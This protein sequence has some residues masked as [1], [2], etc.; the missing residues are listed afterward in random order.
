VALAEKG[1]AFDLEL[2]K[3]WERRTEFLE[4]NPAGDVPVLAEPDGTT[5]I[6]SQVI[7]EYLEESYPAIDLI[8]RTPLQRAETR[9][10]VV[11][12]DRKFA[13]EVSDNLIGEKYFKRLFG[14]GDPH[15]SYI[16]EGLA[17][18]HYHLEYIEYLADRRR[19]LAGDDFSLADIAAAAQLSTADFLGDV[20]WDEHQGAKEWYA[21]VKSRPSFRPILADQ[22][23]G[24]T[25]PQHYADLDF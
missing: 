5:L 25:P 22:V 14:Q 8:G 7:C 24:L 2:E 15:A 6:D 23:S 3:V 17:N 19:W 1:L 9:R 10:L 18:I 16:R 20:P 13:L 11:W 12:F 4:V 21:R